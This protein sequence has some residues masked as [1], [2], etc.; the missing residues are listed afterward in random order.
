M[1][2]PAIHFISSVRQPQLHRSIEAP[3]FFQFIIPQSIGTGRL[4]PVRDISPCQSRN[5]IK[6]KPARPMVIVPDQCGSNSPKI[7][8]FFIPHSGPFRPFQEGFM[9]ALPAQLDR[10]Q[11]MGSDNRQN[12]GGFCKD[13]RDE[14]YSLLVPQKL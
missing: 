6:I 7:G 8:L 1:A 12:Q 14:K 11:G 13:K 4:W 10:R 5:F 2:G 3:L 9:S